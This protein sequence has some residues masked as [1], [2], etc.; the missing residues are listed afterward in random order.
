MYIEIKLKNPLLNIEFIY[1]VCDFFFL[2][3]KFFKSKMKVKTSTKHKLV[4]WAGFVNKMPLCK[5]KEVKTNQGFIPGW[6]GLPYCS[7]ATERD[8]SQDC[9]RT[10]TPN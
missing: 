6:E 1:F 10:G 9:V 4:L 8:I 5:K 7:L 3:N 2:V